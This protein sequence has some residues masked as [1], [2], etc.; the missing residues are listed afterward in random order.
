[1]HLPTF[2]VIGTG[3]GQLAAMH[4]APSDTFHGPA[5]SASTQHV[6][7]LKSEKSFG[8]CPFIY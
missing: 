3:S 2:G 8:N 4:P 6:G 5:T 7:K 1:M